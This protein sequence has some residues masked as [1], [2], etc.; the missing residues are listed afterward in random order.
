[1]QL[2]EFINRSV[3]PESIPSGRAHVTSRREGVTFIV[4]R[5]ANYLNRDRQ[6]LKTIISHKLVLLHMADVLSRFAAT[7]C[8]IFHLKLEMEDDK[9]CVALAHGADWL[10]LFRQFPAM[11]ILDVRGRLAEP[12]AIALERI[13]TEMLPGIFPSLHLIF[14]EDQP[15]S[16]VDTIVAA[17]RL[18]DRPVTFI[19]TKAEFAT[20][21][22][23]YATVSE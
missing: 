14:I 11:K 21:L 23:S 15:A 16:S 22:R 3:G 20:I 12:V 7:F 1:M 2:S 6:P 8:A 5:R 9:Y 13:T 19:E 4:Y 10:S 18:S 17:R